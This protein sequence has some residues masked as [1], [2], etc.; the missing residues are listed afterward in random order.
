MAN[1]ESGGEG[2]NG[3]DG[4]VAMDNLERMMSKMSL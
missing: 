2:G 4:C 3:T 1:D